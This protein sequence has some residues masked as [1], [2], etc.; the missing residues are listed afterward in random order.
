MIFVEFLDLG[1]CEEL[2]CIFHFEDFQN[3]KVFNGC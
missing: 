3:C 1:K 2:Y